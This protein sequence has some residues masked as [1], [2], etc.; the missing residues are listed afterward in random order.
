M[1]RKILNTISNAVLIVFINSV[2]AFAQAVGSSGTTGDPLEVS[3]DFSTKM[4]DIV[5]GPVLKLLAAV[6]LLVGI[7]GLLR[8]RHKLAISCGVAFILILFLPILLSK[9]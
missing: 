7:A 8:G 1:L 2:Q 6:V 5:K 9:I 3:N 4:L